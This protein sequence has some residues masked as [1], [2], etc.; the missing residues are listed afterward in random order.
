MKRRI[1][2]PSWQNEEKYEHKTSTMYNILE[3]HI[4]RLIN[5]Y[6]KYVSCPARYV[7]AIYSD[8]ESIL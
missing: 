1:T 5:I 8:R 2:A 4:I 3:A 6:G 7:Y